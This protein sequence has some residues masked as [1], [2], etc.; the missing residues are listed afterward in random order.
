MDRSPRPGKR[1]MR[2]LHRDA[3]PP[4]APKRPDPAEMGTCFGLDMS[5]DDAPIDPFART[6]ESAPRE[7]DSDADPDSRAPRRPWGRTAPGAI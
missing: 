4:P 2:W 5:F 7:D 3:A 1:L 6:P